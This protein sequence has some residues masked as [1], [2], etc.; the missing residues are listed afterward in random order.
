MIRRI[1]YS[2]KLFM[3]LEKRQ[4]FRNLHNLGIFVMEKFT[5]LLQNLEKCISNFAKHVIKYI[6]LKNIL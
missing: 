2:P 1:D 4:C 3:D 6:Q 5:K